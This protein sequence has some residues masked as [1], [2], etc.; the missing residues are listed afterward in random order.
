MIDEFHKPFFREP[1]DFI[2]LAM[3]IIITLI[4]FLMEAK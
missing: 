1:S 3:S 4:I 2:I